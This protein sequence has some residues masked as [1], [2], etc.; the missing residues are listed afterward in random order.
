MNY[1]RAVM[2]SYVGRHCNARELVKTAKNMELRQIVFRGFWT[3]VQNLRST[4]RL[5]ATHL[6]FKPVFIPHENVE[7]Q[8]KP[9]VPPLFTC[10]EIVSAVKTC[11]PGFEVV[12][13][14]C[15]VVTSVHL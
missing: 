1:L 15:M 12:Q 9:H 11:S 13:S 6:I 7:K 8:F 2:G 4:W 3:C 14:A 5:I 10:F